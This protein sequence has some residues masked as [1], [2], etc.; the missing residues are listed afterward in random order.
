MNSSI[1]SFL[2]IDILKGS[3][4]LVVDNDVDSGVLY[5]I[6]F[7][8]FGANVMTSSSIKGALEILNWFIPNIII[9][10]IR[11]L[12]E[13]VYKLFN[14]LNV[15][16]VENKN[17]IPVIVTSTSST[18]IISEIP[19]VELERYLI[20]PV[21]IDQLTLMIINLFATGKKNLLDCPSKQKYSNKI[22]VKESLLMQMDV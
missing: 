11:F 19:E 4:I 17:Y 3:Q 2:N 20:K 9:C 5:T 12:G 14:K 10:E 18:G 7:T 8:Q 1:A 21:D 16:E 13:S 6:F 22:E 15:M